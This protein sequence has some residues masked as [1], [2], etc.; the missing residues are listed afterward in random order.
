MISKYHL[1]SS[2]D[3]VYKKTLGR[4]IEA[5]EQRVKQEASSDFDIKFFEKFNNFILYLRNSTTHKGKLLTDIEK[6]KADLSVKMSFPFLEFYTDIIHPILAQNTPNQPPR[7]IRRISEKNISNKE[8][9]YYGLDGDN[10]G[11][12]LENLF[13]D[14]SD[15]E[16]FTKIS[17]SITQAI[18]KIREKILASLNGEIIFEAGDD[19]L[20]KGNFDIQSLHDM[21]NIYKSFTSGLTCS[22]GYGRSLKETFLALKM[23]KTQPNKNSVVGIELK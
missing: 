12:I 18:S 10:T 6:F 4:K 16:Q 21:Q 8:I 9:L 13:L 17:T 14:S 1:Y 7:A 15:E 11:E 22:I 3:D 20:F 2:P 23:A 19:L 5:I